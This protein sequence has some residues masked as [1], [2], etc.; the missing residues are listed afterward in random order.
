M[1]WQPI[2]TAPK[3]GTR[4]MGRIEGGE[5]SVETVSVMSW[6]R[7]STGYARAGWMAD[8]RED[9]NPTHWCPL[10]TPE[11]DGAK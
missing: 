5:W 4:V 2:E 10:T 11:S 3:N 9:W 1:N 7:V 8:V 6:G